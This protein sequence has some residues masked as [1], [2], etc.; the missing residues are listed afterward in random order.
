MS[1][2]MVSEGIAAYEAGDVKQARQI[3]SQVVKEDKT[4]EQAWLY[5]GRSLTDPEKRKQCFQMVLKL[6]PDNVEAKRELASAIGRMS[7]AS[8]GDPGEVHTAAKPSAADDARARARAAMSSRFSLKA[9]NA[10]PGAPENMSANDVLGFARTLTQSSIAVLLGREGDS[11]ASW[12]RFWLIV[13]LT[14]FVNGLLRDVR[15]LIIDV[16]FETTPDIGNLIVIPFY[17]IL[18][19][20][21]AVAAGCY[22]SHWYA[23]RQEGG[24]GSLLEHSYGLATIWAPASVLM[25]ILFAI[26]SIRLGERFAL[27]YIVTLEDLLLV[28]LPDLP[29]MSLVLTLIAIAITAYAAF[30]MS[31]RLTAIHSFSGRSGW[32]T[33]LIMLAV[34]AIIF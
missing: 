1:S 10:I 25:G 9:L 23:S 31:R 24:S 19:G 6:N 30:L 18:T 12:W 17:T 33:A 11:R 34:T 3:L 8:E 26:T 7:A 32:I 22:L 5:L 21:V 29:G 20:G 16:R 28:G 13:V 27:N 14:T 2:D 4:N 15:A